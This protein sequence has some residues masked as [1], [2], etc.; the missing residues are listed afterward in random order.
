MLESE[1]IP[2]FISVETGGP[3]GEG[4]LSELVLTN[5]GR[6]GC[7]VIRYRTG[8]LVRPTWQHDL[9]NRFVLLDGGVLGAPTT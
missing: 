2:E 1:F 7:P 6:I 5:L 9:P 8:D 4:E 3:A